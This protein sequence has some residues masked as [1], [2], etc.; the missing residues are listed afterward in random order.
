MKY[1]KEIKGEWNVYTV[2][3]EMT[4][5]DIITLENMNDDIKED[6]KNEEFKYIFDL[7]EVPFIDSSGIAVIIRALSLAVKNHTPI[8]ICGLNDETRRNF[9]IVKFNFGFREFDTM[10]KALKD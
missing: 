8:R 10:D 7:T 6:M 4:F 9:S 2:H 1:E 3:G 5:S